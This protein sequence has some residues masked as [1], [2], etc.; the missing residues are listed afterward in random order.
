MSIAPALS[1]DVGWVVVE[2]VVIVFADVVLVGM[3]DLSVVGRFGGFL[4]SLVGT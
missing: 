2:L 4:Y 3:G 1:E